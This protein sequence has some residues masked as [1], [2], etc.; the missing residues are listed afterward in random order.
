MN[1]VP[2]GKFDGNSEYKLTCLCVAIRI[3]QYKG[4][5]WKIKF[6]AVTKHQSYYCVLKVCTVTRNN[7]III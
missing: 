6:L 4:H 5:N 2:V 3:S 7:K 1:I